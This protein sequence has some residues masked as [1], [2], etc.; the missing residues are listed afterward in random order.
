MSSA[1][2]NLP[3]G[4]NVPAGGIAFSAESRNVTLTG[5]QASLLIEYKENLD[6][7]DA[8]LTVRALVKNGISDARSRLLEVTCGSMSLVPNST[9]V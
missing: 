5:E 4:N 3:P 6:R 7:F 9:H 1:P 2:V 8:F